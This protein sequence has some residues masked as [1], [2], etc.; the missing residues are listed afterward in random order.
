MASSWLAKE[1]SIGLG[2]LAGALGGT[3][4]GKGFFPI[5]SLVLGRLGM[6][7]IGQAAQ[8]GSAALA[9][10]PTM[11]ALH[12]VG[13]AGVL[14][15]GAVV[16][17]FLM[18]NVIFYGLV[19]GLFRLGNAGKGL[20]IPTTTKEWGFYHLESGPGIAGDVF[21][22]TETPMAILS[23]LASLELESRD[24]WF[25]RRMASVVAASENYKNVLK[26][27]ME[28]A[29]Q[30]Y[31]QLRGMA[32]PRLEAPNISEPLYREIASWSEEESS[33]L[34]RQWTALTDIARPLVKVGRAKN[35]VRM[36]QE[37][38]TQTIGYGAGFLREFYER[39]VAPKMSQAQRQN[40][41]STK[42]LAAHDF[43]GLAKFYLKGV[44]GEKIMTS[45]EDSDQNVWMAV[46]N[47]T[48]TRFFESI[49]AGHE[50][51]PEDQNIVHDASAQE[52]SDGK[53]APLLMDSHFSLK[54]LCARSF[55]IP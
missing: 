50:I 39:A 44:W 3:L 52:G 13:G 35:Q 53:P 2:I 33:S 18:R 16:K 40:F 23:L 15:Y 28:S 12:W 10:H 55:S 38:L 37:Q 19:D 22:K 7:G 42:N 47:A 27:P 21:Y 11:A 25:D 51:Q 36:T 45:F 29:R 20:Q 48:L 17:D 43:V 41:W 5:G 49:V 1:G 14:G 46:E 54:D 4:W 26:A 34:Q 31:Y 24:L 32:A 6:Q 8:A 9:V 30:R